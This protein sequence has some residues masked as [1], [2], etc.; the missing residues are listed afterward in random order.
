VTEVLT[1]EIGHALG[2]AHTTDTPTATNSPL[3][4]AIMY[5]TTHG[6]NRGATLGAMDG[7]DIRQLYPTN[8]SLPFT[9]PRYMDI[10]TAPAN[11]LP[12]NIGVNS[13]QL[14]G[15]HLTNAPLTVAAY[16]PFTFDGS[17][18]STD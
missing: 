11:K 15:Y 9:Y 3:F 7:P 12:T 16:A 13:I 4:Q 14:R 6:D 17:S 18:P 1:H 8:I 10:V 5:Y 2:L